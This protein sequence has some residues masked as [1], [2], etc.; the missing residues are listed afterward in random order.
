MNKQHTYQNLGGWFN[1]QDIYSKMVALHTDGAHFVEIGTCLGKS[2]SF[3]GVEIYNSGK[4]ITFETVDTFKGSPSEINGKHKFF[5]EI[6]VKA[7]AEKALKNLPVKIIEGSSVEVS[8]NYKNKSL[9]FVFIDGSHVFEDVYADIMAWKKKIKKGGYIGGHDYDNT[10]VF[11]AVQ[12]ALKKDCPVSRN[13]WLI[14][15]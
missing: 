15:L 5:T 11:K 4:D 1:F 12:K 9:D 13:S 10:H 8:K 6:D 3:M 7:R 14:Q 2:A